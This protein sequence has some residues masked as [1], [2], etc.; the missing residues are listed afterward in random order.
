VKT[1]RTPPHGLGER[2]HLSLVGPGEIDQAVGPD[3]DRGQDHKGVA[4]NHARQSVLRAP[5]DREALATRPTSTL[6][7]STP[8]NPSK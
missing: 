7:R 2:A 8:M 1:R 6:G 4:E 3:A 5:F